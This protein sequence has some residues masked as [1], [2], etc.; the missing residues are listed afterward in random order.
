MV[1]LL[2]VAG[3]SSEGT[4]SDTPTV[5]AT[6]RDVAQTTEATSVGSDHTASRDP[7]A[8][9]PGALGAYIRAVADQRRSDRWLGL[10]Y[11]R[12]H[13]PVSSWRSPPT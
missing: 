12:T 6:S 2:G 4:R 8:P 13:K 11:H 1:L 7:E 3:C 5:A 10:R 9:D